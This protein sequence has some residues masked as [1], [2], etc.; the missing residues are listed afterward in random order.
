MVA[1][2]WNQN[3][4]FNGSGTELASNNLDKANE[5]NFTNV[6]PYK[7]YVLYIDAV[8]GSTTRVSL[9]EFGLYGY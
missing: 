5:Y 3:I 6:N 7:F 2:D 8:C 1:T 9:G 4:I